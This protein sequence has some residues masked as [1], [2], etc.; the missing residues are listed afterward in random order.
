MGKLGEVICCFIEVI[1]IGCWGYIF[2]KRIIFCFCIYFVNIYFG[3]NMIMSELKKKGWNW[4]FL[5]V[6]FFKIYV[7]DII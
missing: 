1:L 7:M 5:Y 3:K 6:F 2:E 4:L